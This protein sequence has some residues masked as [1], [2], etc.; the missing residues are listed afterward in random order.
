MGKMNYHEHVEQV[1]GPTMEIM[2]RVAG[3]MGHISVVPV[4]QSGET[5]AAGGH[6]ARVGEGQT[7]VRVSGTLGAEGTGP[8][9]QQVGEAQAQAAAQ[10]SETK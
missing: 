8:F 1:D 10:A 5:F 6:S 9:Y 7:A 4:A 3:D 2:Q